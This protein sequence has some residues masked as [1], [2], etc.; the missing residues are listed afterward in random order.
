ML[1]PLFVTVAGGEPA[2]L[3]ISVLETDG[4]KSSA[5]ITLWVLNVLQVRCVV[6]EVSDGVE[7]AC[8][9]MIAASCNW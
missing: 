1:V 6:M 4:F 9:I 7:G 8:G 3:A 2:H 5:K